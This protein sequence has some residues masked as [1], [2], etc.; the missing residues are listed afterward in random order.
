MILENWITKCDKRWNETELRSEKSCCLRL[1]LSHAKMKTR[2]DEQHQLWNRFWV[3]FERSWSFDILLD[4]KFIFNPF[5]ISIYLMTYM[6]DIMRTFYLF[7]FL[8]LNYWKINT[9][10]RI[11]END[12]LF[13]EMQIFGCS[14][15]SH[16][17]MDSS[18]G[19]TRK[20][21][22]S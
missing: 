10:R 3:S 13:I 8:W 16:P 5:F 21:Q 9:Q 15:G 14:Q 6:W 11:S 4:K 22:I 12:N 20:Y 17:S 19:D 7:I 18:P 1:K 2:W